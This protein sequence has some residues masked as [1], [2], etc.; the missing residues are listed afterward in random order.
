MLVC[1]D[2]STCSGVA[3]FSC[4]SPGEYTMVS[5]VSTSNNLDIVRGNNGSVPFSVDDGDAALSVAFAPDDFGGVQA[6]VSY[7][8][9]Q[10]YYPRSLYASISSVFGPAIVDSPVLPASGTWVIP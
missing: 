6:T 10:K 4:L 9:M 3:R 7:T 5:G 1:H 8:F 2:T